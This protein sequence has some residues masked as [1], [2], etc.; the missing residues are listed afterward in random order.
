MRKC[1]QKVENVGFQFVYLRQPTRA[2]Y[3]PRA[4]SPAKSSTFIGFAAST[5]ALFV[6]AKSP[7]FSLLNLRTSLF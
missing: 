5:S 6:P 7:K 4:L 2:R 1:A 3:S